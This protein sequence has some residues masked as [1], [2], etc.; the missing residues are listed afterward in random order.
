MVETPSPQLCLLTWS[1]V[2]DLCENQSY[3]GKFNLFIPP[4][5]QIYCDAI[6]THVH[7]ALHESGCQGCLCWRNKPEQTELLS[8]CWDSTMLVIRKKDFSLSDG[9]IDHEGACGFQL[10]FHTVVLMLQFL[11]S[12]Y[13]QRLS[14]PKQVKRTRTDFSL[15]LTSCCLS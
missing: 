9:L 8:S 3:Y 1:N 12:H 11:V 5:T 15:S 4:L 6:V 2:S 10:L 7:Q 14:F 13:S